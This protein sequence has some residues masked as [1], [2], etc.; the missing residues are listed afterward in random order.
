MCFSLL[1]FFPVKIYPTYYTNKSQSS[2]LRVK[3]VHLIMA[4]C[5]L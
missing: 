4:T 2:F 1:T 5:E 3:F